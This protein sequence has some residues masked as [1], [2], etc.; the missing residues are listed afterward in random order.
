VEVLQ[1]RNRAVYPYVVFCISPRCI[2]IVTSGNAMFRCFWL[3]GII[4]GSPRPFHDC[5]AK[6]KSTA[7]SDHG[8]KLSRHSH[9]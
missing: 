9:A 1:P 4:A 5:V 3:E 7:R 2:I 6:G 8:Q